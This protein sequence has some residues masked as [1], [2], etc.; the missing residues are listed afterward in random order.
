MQMRL[1]AS[2]EAPMLASTWPRR[3]RPSPPTESLCSDSVLIRVTHDRL[4]GN[5]PVV[6]LA[7]NP[8]SNQGV[9]LDRDENNLRKPSAHPLFR[10]SRS[11]KT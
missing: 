11:G 9:G 4:I 6:E 8:E 2:P 1:G 10:F 7:Q 3:T 5:Q